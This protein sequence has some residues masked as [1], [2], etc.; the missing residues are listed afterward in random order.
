MCLVAAL[1]GCK[2]GVKGNDKGAISPAQQF[3]GIEIVKSGSAKASIVLPADATVEEKFAASELVAYVKAITGAELQTSPA[4]VAGLLPIRFGT[5]KGKNL[6]ITPPLRAAL[7]QLTFRGYVLYAGKDG[8]QIIGDTPRSMNIANYAM[9]H[10]YGKVYWYHPDTPE[11]VPSAQDFIVPAQITVKNPAFPF[12]NPTAYGVWTPPPVLK[13][14]SKIGFTHFS[15][16]DPT[17]ANDKR[18][19]EQSDFCDKLGFRDCV[20]LSVTPEDLLAVKGK[21]QVQVLEMH[22]DYFGL[23]NNKRVPADASYAYKGL[24]CSQPCTTHPEGLKFMAE[25]FNRM[26]DQY[27][28]DTKIRVTLANTDYVGLWCECDACRKLDDP[29]SDKVHGRA[30]NRWWNFVN[31]MCENVLKKHPNVYF[32]VFAY[33]DFENPPT[34]VKP[35]RSDRV[36]IEVCPYG[37][38]YLHTLDDPKCTFNLYWS[39]IYK[40]WWDLGYRTGEFSYLY[41]S[42]EMLHY[43]P[44]ERTVTADFK[45][46]AK[47]GAIGEQIPVSGGIQHYID[48]NKHPYYKSYTTLHSWEARWQTA[49]MACHF[50]WNPSDDYMTVW[51]DVSSHYY[52]AAWPAMKQYRLLLEKGL[53]EAN[54]HAGDGT[55]ITGAALFGKAYDMVGAQASGLLVEALAAVNSDPVRK[56]RIEMEKELFDTIWAKSSVQSVN[57]NSAVRMLRTTGPLK[58]D[59][60][61]DEPDWRQAQAYN[62]LVMKKMLGLEEHYIPAEPETIVR[63][64]SDKDNIF[65][66]IECVKAKGQAPMDDSDSIWKNSHLEIFLMPQSFFRKVEYYQVAFD[67]KGRRDSA[68]TRGGSDRDPKDTLDFDVAISDLP[69]R[70]IAEVRIPTK[71]LGGIAPGDFLKVNVGRSMVG[72]DGKKISASFS[73]NGFHGTS[74]FVVFA[75]Y[76][77]YGL[78]N[79]SFEEFM[80]NPPQDSGAWEFAGG[81]YPQVWQFDP[82]FPGK[83]EILA[84][85]PKHGKYFARISPGKSAT[86]LLRQK[87]NAYEDVKDFMI[88]IPVSGSVRIAIEDPSGKVL[89]EKVCRTDS[90]AWRRIEDVLKVNLAGPKYFIIQGLDGPFE[91]DCM[92]VFPIR[93]DGV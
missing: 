50:N 59:G 81:L 82:K 38:C 17:L 23:K 64:L 34:W 47:H 18:F 68:R 24:P 30:A 78:L 28:A 55:G 74:G 76:L 36:W 66:G 85:K 2:T 7:D 71:K 15:G 73:Q 11:D 49:Y 31:F 29:E 33:Q 54:I 1:S 5:A 44:Y 91:V 12:I 25:N 14:I 62:K 22:P 43:L 8:I 26:L 9:I 21:T 3:A 93:Q 39:K 48:P 41:G 52:G 77:G 6:A 80:K 75:D 72:A 88:K 10:Q 51:E 40:A 63:V 61:L 67:R 84:E 83:I 53:R 35:F 37:R 45:T 57:F 60:I 79:A 16:P 56:Q 70:W 92:T 87:L 86:P 90:R 42:G 27:P 4:P 46:Y 69:D 20:A 19:I 65:F 58:I 89:A 32:Y 13:L